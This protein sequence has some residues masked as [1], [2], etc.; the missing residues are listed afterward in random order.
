M[1]ATI[2]PKSHPKYLALPILGPYLDDF[3]Q[4][5]H[6]HGYTR[7][8]IRNQLK[9]TRHIII[10]LQKQAL[11]SISELTHC[12]FEKAWR[13]FHQKRPAI[14]GTVRQFQKFLDEKGELT[15]PS[16]VPKTRS[17][18]ELDDF[19]AFLKNVRGLSA[20]TIQSYLGYLRRFLKQKMWGDVH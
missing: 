7:G 12:D 18:K 3:T 13:H 4:W 6:Q 16:P 14:A 19:A 11:H 5:A 9:D 17:D 8:T 1:I 20:T 2:R 15:P 10:F